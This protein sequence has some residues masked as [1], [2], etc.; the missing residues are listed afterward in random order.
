MKRYLKDLDIKTRIDII[1]NNSELSEKVFEMFY[2]NNMDQ[3]E[4]ESKLM[5]GEKQWKNI[6]IHDHYNSFFLTLINWYN[7]ICNLDKDYLCQKG[8]DLY[9]E[10]LPLK[11]EYENITLDTVEEENRYSELED[12]LEEKCKELLSICEEQLHEYEHYTDQ[13]IKEYLE[14]QLEENDLFSN[15]YIINNDYTK[16]YYDYIKVYE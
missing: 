6:E 7:F 15:Y 3:Q 12:I 14:F 1:M 5:F 16:V 8:I 4:E 9:N 13:D 10:I 2:D 11:V